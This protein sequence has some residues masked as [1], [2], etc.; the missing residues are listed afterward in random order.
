M[1]YGPVLGLTRKKFKS[2]GKTE[3]S[4]LF[5]QSQSEASGVGGTHARIESHT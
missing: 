2:R 5:I 4:I 3:L 1:G